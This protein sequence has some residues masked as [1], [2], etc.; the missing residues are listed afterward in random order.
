[1][2]KT[3]TGASNTTNPNNNNN[4]NPL[5]TSLVNSLPKIDLDRT[6]YNVEDNISHMDLDKYSF[7]A[8][9]QNIEFVGS[10]SNSDVDGKQS[11]PSKSPNGVGIKQIGPSF[12]GIPSHKTIMKSKTTNLDEKPKD[13]LR[14]PSYKNLLGNPKSPV[15]DAGGS[16]STLGSVDSSN[17]NNLLK[18]SLN[19]LDAA[20]SLNT[21]LNVSV[22]RVRELQSSFHRT[23]TTV[24]ETAILDKTKDDDG[25]KKIN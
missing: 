13:S 22:N 10:G 18:P 21:S 8:D 19:N 14:K 16:A 20:N 4:N 9:V 5:D 12:L 23:K 1:M 11:S 24:V 25:Q 3:N 6:I 17:N 2:P 15:K 7:Y